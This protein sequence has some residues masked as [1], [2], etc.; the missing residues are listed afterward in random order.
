MEQVTAMTPE[1]IQARL[2]ALVEQSISL[3]G[4]MRDGVI[5]HASGE[6]YRDAPHWQAAQG[7]L[8]IAEQALYYAGL[9]ASPMDPG[10][11]QAC[12]RERRHINEIRMEFQP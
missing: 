11:K 9:M 12:Q 6:N 4:V 3:M 10:V 7:L 2:S 8:N 5:E 1:E